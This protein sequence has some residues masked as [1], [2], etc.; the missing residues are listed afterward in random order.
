MTSKLISFCQLQTLASP[1]E[2]DLDVGVDNYVTERAVDADHTDEV[3][4][5]HHDVD[6]DS[7]EVD[8]PVVSKVCVSFYVLSKL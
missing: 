4:D 5:D 8:N 7:M 3:I 6:P 1:C 2:A